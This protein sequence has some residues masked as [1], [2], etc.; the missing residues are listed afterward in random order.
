[1]NTVKVVFPIVAPLY[2]LG[3][4]DFMKL[5]FCTLTGK[6]LFSGTVV[7][8]TFSKISPI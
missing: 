4:H 1:M 2:H 6:L 8:K 7:L 3:G 5:R